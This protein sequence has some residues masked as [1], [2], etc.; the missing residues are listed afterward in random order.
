LGALRKQ[1]K[2]VEM[3]M[4]LFLASSSCA[5][6]QSSIYPVFLDAPHILEHADIPGDP[7]ALGG[8]PLSSEDPSLTPRAWW[9]WN[10]DS[11]RAVGLEETLLY[12]RNKLKAERFDVRAIFFLMFWT[13][14]V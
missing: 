9:R 3:G 8:A 13:D 4:H 7:S 1:A 11:L 14:E 6:K 10:T 5:Y 2:D 12:L